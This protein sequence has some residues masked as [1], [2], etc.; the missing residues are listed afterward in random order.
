MIPY[1]KQEVTAEDVAQV[2]QVLTSDF[3]TQGK[4]VPEFERAVASYCSAQ[5]GVAVN[6]GTSALHLACL[7]LGVGE[8]DLV[9]TTPITF[10]ASANCAR[11]CSADVDFVDIDPGSFNMCPR[12]L[13][14]KLKR[15]DAL[16]RLPKVVIPVHLCGQSCAMERIG[17]LAKQY[18]FSIIED[19]C[20][21]I[22]GRYQD[23][24][25]G[26]CHY[27]DITVFS[28][29]PVKI[30]TTAE[31]GMATT[32]RSE[33]A[34]KMSLLRSHAITRDPQ[35][36]VGASDGSWYYQQVGLGFN[37]RLTDIQAALGLSQIQRLDRYV[38]ARHRIADRYDLLLQGLPVEVPSRYSESYSSFHL[39]VI[40][41]QLEQF[42][43]GKKQIVEQL[44]EAGV[45][46]NVH[47]IPVHTQPYYQ[48]LG[49][50]EG[51]FQQAEK[52]YSEALSLPIYPTLTEEQQDH[53]VACLRDIRKK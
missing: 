29:H 22:G 49:F 37:Y 43:D 39:Y 44:R 9:W 21:A 16:G 34:E 28:F 31:G 3:I 20:H 52:Y 33:L 23:Q 27:S 7:A 2:V 41:L 47:Y 48:E 40:R 15:A 8:G 11:Y 4:T 38:T 35:K 18:G 36:M 12:A 26:C 10:V 45:G 32:N 46:V 5:Y 19:A 51:L 50:H 25:V 42:Q 17:E 14:E 6:S 24:P 53:V 30:I 1:G 13:E